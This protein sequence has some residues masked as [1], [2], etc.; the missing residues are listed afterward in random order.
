MVTFVVIW[1][2]ILHFY[3]AFYA[4]YTNNYAGPLSHDDL[5]FN[6]TM[7]IDFHYVKNQ[8]NKLN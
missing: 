7:I 8:E 5:Y 3:K 4:I 6:S 1:E 2:S